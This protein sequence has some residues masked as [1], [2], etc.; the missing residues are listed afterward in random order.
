MTDPDLSRTLRRMAAEWVLANE[1][2]VNRGLLTGDHLYPLL[3]AV[4]AAVRQ[5][6]AER[7]A[8]IADQWANSQSCGH[9]TDNPCCHVRTGASIAEAIRSAL[10]RDGGRRA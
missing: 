2:K 9:H 10:L 6:Q 7:D 1:D 3:E 5:E 8:Q 4:A